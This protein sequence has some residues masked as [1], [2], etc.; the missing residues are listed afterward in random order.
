M[1][2]GTSSALRLVADASAGLAGNAS[3]SAAEQQ[4]LDTINRRI[5][6]ADSLE[7]LLDFLFTSVQPVL[8]CDRIGV[9]FVEED[10]VRL[11]AHHT[12]ASYEPVIL[13]EG[14]AEDLA[15]S[16]LERVLKSGAPRIID[17][18]EA[19]LRERPGSQSTKLLLKEGVRSSMTCPLLV[20]ARIVGLLFFSARRPGAYTERDVR[21]HL[22][23][24]ERLSQAVDKARRIEQ[25]AQATQAYAEM[26]GFVSHELKSPLASIVMDAAVLRDG[27]AGEMTEA[28]REVVGKMTRKAEYLLNLIR[29]YLD[30]A[31]IEGGEL[32][33]HPRDGVDFIADVVEAACDIVAPQ[34]AEKRMSIERV[35]P[36]APVVVS[37]DPDLI[38]IVVVN[39]ISNA[40]KYGREQGTVRLTVERGPSGFGLRVWNEGPGFPASQRPRLFRR[41][42]RLDTPELRK[43]KGTGV[44]LY[45]SWRI[46]VTHGGRLTADSREG[47][48]AEFR[49]EIPQPIPTATAAGVARTTASPGA[50]GV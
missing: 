34:V 31:R 6:A 40:V 28:Q 38:K 2:M 14:Y 5:A 10:G 49:F 7:A 12:R 41:F 37:C 18:L 17:D 47:E 27:Y 26:L 35:F 39:L 30:L 19:Y 43:R 45:T 9:S 16:S 11:V 50:A 13:K 15:G 24:A 32:K 1:T 22:A 20:D 25:L 48:W 4:V 42:S 21:F 44:G 29:E 33:A 8:T 23:I 46:V 36:T 3:F